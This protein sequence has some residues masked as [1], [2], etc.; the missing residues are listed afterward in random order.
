M[1]H[2]EYLQ[3]IKFQISFT[4]PDTGIQLFDIQMPKCGPR[5]ICNIHSIHTVFDASSNNIRW[6]ISA[7]ME[8][9]DTWQKEFVHRAYHNDEFYRRL[10]WTLSGGRFQDGLRETNYPYPIAY[11]YD[12]MR[13]MTRTSSIAT[14][15]T[16]DVFI[17]YTIEPIDS[18]RLTAIT[19]RRGT[20]RHAREGGPEA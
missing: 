17:F 14:G 18:T 8:P 10:V 6:V 3:V 9:S 16:W 12:K 7:S 2:Q 4:P 11:P 13:W 5:S 19:V 15:T 1:P 20:T